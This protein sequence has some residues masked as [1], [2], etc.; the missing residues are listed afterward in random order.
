MRPLIGIS[1]D[2]Q[3]SGSFSKRAH[4]ALRQHYFDAVYAAG[5][6]PVALP[7]NMA[8][9]EEYLQ[10]VEGVVI[11]GGDYPSPGWW[12]GNPDVETP[13]PRPDADVAFIRLALARDVPLLG[14]CA[15]MQTLAV[16]TGGRLHWNIKNCLG[17][18]GHRTVPLEQAA[19]P[20]AVAEG[21]LLHRLTGKTTLTVN[22][23]HNEGVATVGEG[24]RIVATAPDGVVEAVEVPGCRFALGV[25]WHP[26]MFMEAGSDDRRI[27]E[28]LVAAAME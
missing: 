18:K 24:A 21:S 1:M 17:V 16:A 4:Y 19:H 26:E 13:H 6:L 10:T 23:Q 7:L 15:G 9:Q 11:P 3:E 25:E 27:F 14:I 20:V 5:G 8:A 12:Y 2:W 22:S 28:G